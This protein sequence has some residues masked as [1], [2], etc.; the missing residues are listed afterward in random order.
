MERGGKMSAKS[1]SSLSVITVT[2]YQRKI[3]LLNLLP[4]KRHQ[5]RT[6]GDFVN[7]CSCI[8]SKTSRK[9][10]LDVRVCP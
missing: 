9:R 7:A 5:V 6:Y 4:L 1:T 3:W 2:S 8:A 10:I